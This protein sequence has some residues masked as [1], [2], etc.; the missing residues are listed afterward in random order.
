MNNF[1]NQRLNLHFKEM[2]RYLKYVFNDF[3]VIALMFFVGALGLVY[4]NFLKELNGGQ[5]WEKVVI[6]FV[7]LVALQICGLATLVKQ[8]DQVFISPREYEFKTY[9][10]ASFFYSLI[11][12]IL[13]EALVVFIL[14]PFVGVSLHWT[15]FQ[16]IELFVLI[17]IL[18]WLILKNDLAN[19]YLDFSKSVFERVIVNLLIPLIILITAIYGNL[20]VGV[21]LAL[22][23]AIGLEITFKR[24]A[25]LI[26]WKYLIASE[27]RR[28]A[29]VY[30]FFSLFQDVPEVS[31]KIKR[32]RWATP[33]LKL[34]KTNHKHTFTRLYLLTFIRDGEISSLF[35]RLLIIG[36]LV[37]VFVKNDVLS[38]CIYDLF[39]YLVGFQL[40]PFYKVFDDNV[41]VHI[42]PISEKLR[43]HNFRSV[44]RTMLLIEILVLTI[45]MLI[46]GVSIQFIVFA[47]IIGLFE[48]YCLTGP[49]LKMKFKN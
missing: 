1:F 41:F 46:S 38:V 35:F 5:W 26:D 40:I 37:I 18:K 33:L 6:I 12:A 22:L 13:F 30:R 17:I 34:I 45:G 4:S 39:I 15:V 28:M 31:P 48:I 14:M 25:T 24:R 21:V 19:C 7:L 43:M 29:V 27:E 8:P 3:F 49:Y 10:K 20:H 16:I 9:L 44:V 47:V 32:R 42:Y 36:F 23:F 11:L 2:A